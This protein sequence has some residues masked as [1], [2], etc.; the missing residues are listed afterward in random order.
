MKK[1]LLISLLVGVLTLSSCGT[2]KSISETSSPEAT[3]T[4]MLSEDFNADTNK[5]CELHGVTYQI[6]ANWKIDES[7]SVMRYYPSDGMLYVTFI[8]STDKITNG[9]DESKQTFINGFASGCNDFTLKESKDIK[10]SGIEAFEFEFECTV[11]KQKV[12]GDS[13]VFDV[14]GGMIQF[15]MS[16]NS[17]ASV[18]YS[19]DFDSILKS[20]EMETSTESPTMI[21]VTTPPTATPFVS[22]ETIAP[23]EKNQSKA[24]SSSNSDRTVY[25]GNTGD[26][27][28]RASC[29]TLKGK[30]HAI[31]LDDAIAQKREACRRCKP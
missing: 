15:I 24:S 10:I 6:P 29:S 3:S 26:K 14:S 19:Q 13:V 31:S 17:N 8:E 4:I 5:H 11:D 20:I 18:G 12:H 30:G 7:P 16:T 25:I 28:H 27:Y 2:S 23:I 9:T 22:A 1:A 21:P